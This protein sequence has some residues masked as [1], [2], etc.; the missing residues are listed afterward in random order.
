MNSTLFSVKGEETAPEMPRSCEGQKDCATHS[1]VFTERPQSN[2][3]QEGGGDGVGRHHRGPVGV[4]MGWAPAGTCGDGDGMWWAPMGT[5][6]DG[7][8]TSENQ[9]G[10]EGTAAV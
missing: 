2:R 7:V 6:G 1:R 9:W 3:G 10:W 5:S 8:G 4:G